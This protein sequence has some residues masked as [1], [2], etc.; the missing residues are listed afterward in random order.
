MSYNKI[1]KV[2]KSFVTNVTKRTN[3]QQKCMRRSTNNPDYIYMLGNK[4]IKP[5]VKS[6]KNNRRRNVSNK[7]VKRGRAQKSYRTKYRQRGGDL[8]GNITNSVNTLRSGILELQPFQKVLPWEG[9]FTR[10]FK[11]IM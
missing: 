8:Y 7:R 5:V 3:K 9:H 4:C 11:H 2:Y 1:G 10:D 6:R